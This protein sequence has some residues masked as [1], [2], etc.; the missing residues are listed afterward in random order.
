MSYFFEGKGGQNL[1]FSES[2]HDLTGR[3]AEPPDF[4]RLRLRLQPF[5]NKTAPAPGEL[6]GGKLLIRY[7]Y[8][9]IYFVD[10]TDEKYL[11]QCEKV[12]GIY[13]FPPPSPPGKLDSPQPLPPQPPGN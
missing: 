12:Y 11:V 9:K 13:G 7:N 3:V 1:G 2:K 8:K 5:K 6:L 4:R 10:L